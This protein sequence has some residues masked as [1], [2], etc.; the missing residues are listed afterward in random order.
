MSEKKE[1]T[2]RRAKKGDGSPK[3]NVGLWQKI[4]DH[5]A[6]KFSGWVIAIISIIL[7][8][9]IPL[10]MRENR[11]L[12]YAVNPIRTEIVSTENTSSLTILYDGRNLGSSNIT[13]VQIALW[14]SGDLSIVHDDILKDII[15]NTEP[16]VNILEA[17]I[18][19]NMSDSEITKLTIDNSIENLRVGRIPVTWKILEKNDGASIQIIYQGSADVKI[20]VT[21]HIKDYGIVRELEYKKESSWSIYLLCVIVAATFTLGIAIKNSNKYIWTISIILLVT[22]IVLM[23][24]SVNDVV[25]KTTSFGPPFGF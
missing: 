13:A 18:V 23:G 24:I 9:V 25:N 1:K 4:T 14:N 3:S 19:K 8:I 11:E 10:N 17:K 12:V 6:F 16:S 20:S 21:G 5:P 15:I 2:K 22:A 7:A